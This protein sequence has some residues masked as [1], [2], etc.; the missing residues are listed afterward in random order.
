LYGREPSSL[1]LKKENGLRL[2]EKR[3]LG[4]IFGRMREEL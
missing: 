4:K 2:E 1:I 3:V